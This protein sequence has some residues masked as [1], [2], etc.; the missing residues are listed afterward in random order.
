MDPPAITRM[1]SPLGVRLTSRTCV[2]F[3]MQERLIRNADVAGQYRDGVRSLFRTGFHSLPPF[4]VQRFSDQR[5]LDRL[6]PV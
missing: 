5:D 1:K 6:G 4:T 3:T 2:I